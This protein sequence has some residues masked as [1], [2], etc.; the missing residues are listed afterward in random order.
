MPGF[1]YRYRQG[2]GQP[3]IQSF[4]FLDTETLSVGDMVNIETGRA[5]LAV[6]GDVALIGVAVEA[7]DGTAGTSA[8]RCITDADA[9]YAVDDPFARVKGQHLGLS[10]LTGAQGVCNSTGSEFVVV[11]DCGAEEATL[12]SITAD[13]HFP[14]A[15]P[16]P[17]GG[18]LNAAIARAV[19]RYHREHVGRGPTK[20]QAFY[21]N[22]VV[23][24]LLEDM[25]TTA[26]RSLVARGRSDA[27][28]RMREAFQTAIGEDLTGS[29]EELT[30]A[31]VIAFMSANSL[32]PDMAVEVFV[33]D[34]PVAGAD[35]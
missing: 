2:G 26:E 21:R 34:R 16:R 7:H 20:A 11:T 14:G 3:T 18:D 1:E 31:K 17:T 22:N 25:M 32:Q 5:D 33:L 19:V 9:V 4:V 23:V 30:G 29:I 35:G 13:R 12:V 6:A 8:I 28:E 27:V 10:G 24:V 15:A